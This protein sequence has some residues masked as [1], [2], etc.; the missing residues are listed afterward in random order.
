MEVEKMIQKVCD[1]NETPC[2]IFAVYK[3]EWFGFF[4]WDNIFGREKLVWGKERGVGP[5]K[6]CLTTITRQ[7]DTVHHNRQQYE[8][9]RNGEMYNLRL[10]L[11]SVLLCVCARCGVGTGSRAL[12]AMHL[13]PMYRL[14]ISLPPPTANA[15]FSSATACCLPRLS[16]LWAPPGRNPPA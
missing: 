3:I 15:F 1:K 4:Q 6:K 7:R 11:P 16:F 10:V 13:R 12:C 9:R 8:D 5:F 2:R 14:T